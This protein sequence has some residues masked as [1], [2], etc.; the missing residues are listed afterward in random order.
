[1]NEEGEESDEKIADEEQEEEF[2]NEV[3]RLLIFGVLLVLII[4]VPALV[5]MW[6]ASQ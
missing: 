6:A 1:M 4:T 3:N 5:V 2:D